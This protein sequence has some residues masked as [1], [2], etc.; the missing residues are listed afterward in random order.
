LDIN[1]IFGA[2]DSSSN[3][4]DH[5]G[6]NYY[7]PRTLPK[8]DENH[9]K[10]FIRMFWKLI[11]NHLSYN[12]HLID[13][14]NQSDSSLDTSSIEYAGEKILYARA[15]NFIKRIDLEDDYHQ[16]ILK[17]ENSK[18]LKKSYKLIIR[19][20]E[21]EE[22]YEKCALLKKQLDYIKFLS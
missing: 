14:F 1:K 13:F 10:Y 8:I 11:T 5:R 22:E 18:E 6:Y 21:D 9:P 12:K 2:F 7:S 19:F 20:Y 4:W 16:K 17:E 15:Y 3:E